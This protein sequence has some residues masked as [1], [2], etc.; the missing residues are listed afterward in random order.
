MYRLLR[1]VL[2]AYT[3]YLYKYQ[4]AAILLQNFLVTSK[5]NLCLLETINGKVF[6]SFSKTGK[7]EHSFSDKEC[8]F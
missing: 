7:P 4:L 3:I 5:I 1:L 8:V 6:L 2:E